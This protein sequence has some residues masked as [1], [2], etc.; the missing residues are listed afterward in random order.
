MLITSKRLGLSF[1]I[2]NN[3]S[4]GFTKSSHLSLEGFKWRYKFN[5]KG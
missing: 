2:S 4:S 5:L 1:D 3:P